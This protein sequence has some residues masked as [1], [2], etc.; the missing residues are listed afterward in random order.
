MTR[1]RIATASAAALLVILAACSSTGAGN[2]ASTSGSGQVLLVGSYHGIKGQYSTIQAAVNAAKPGAWILV[3]PGD[4]HE[5]D[6]LTHVPSATQASNGDFGGVVIDKARVHVR[7]MNRN[8]VIIDGTR[9]GAPHPCDSSPQYQTYGATRD[10]KAI[11]R[12]GIVVFEADNTWIENMTVCNF[13]NGTGSAG[14]EI[15]WDGGQGSGKIGMHGYWGSYLTATSTF[16]G[17]ESVIPTYGIFSNSAAGPAE[18]NQVYASN[19]N[20]SGAYVGACQQLC[21]VTIDHSWFEYN[22]LGYSGTNSGGQVIVENSQ[23]DHN[24]DGFDTNTQ[25]GGDPPP[26]QDGRCPNGKTSPITHTRSCWVFMNNYVHDNNNADVPA[27][28]SAAQGPIG[29]G[30]TVSG[31]R[32]DTVM[33]NTFENNGSWGILFVPYPDSGHPAKGVTCS[34]SGGVQTPGFGCVYDPEGNA[35][36]DNTFI[37]NG[38]FG[39]PT[40]GDYGEIALNANQP[41]NCFVG[42]NAPDGSTP[43]NLEQTQPTCGALTTAPQTGGAL[44]GQVLCDTGFG[45]C[46]PGSNYPKITTNVVMRPLPANLPT[47]PNPCKGVPKNAWCP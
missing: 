3:G 28:G 11:G 44:L 38:Y 34:N 42:N 24:Q 35:L 32:F 12:N 43:A 20:D 18:W 45:A 40:N 27:S 8:S 46:P 33:H 19:M 26:P 14:Y 21:D 9:A 15:W 4:Y 2:S 22:A 7:G 10:G 16:N 36:L 1:T 23:F 31:G 41:Q 6:D 30:M 47:M 29:T 5:T 13:L 25:I 17:S 39:N 37:H